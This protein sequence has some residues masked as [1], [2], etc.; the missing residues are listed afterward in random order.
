[1]YLDVNANLNYKLEP[2]VH[3]KQFW[4]QILLY[5]LSVHNIPFVQIKMIDFTID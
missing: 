4:F 3:T 1:M 2:L 5:L